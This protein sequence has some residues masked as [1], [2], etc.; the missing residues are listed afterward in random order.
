MKIQEIIK[1]KNRIV[2]AESVS[3]LKQ[4]DYG[5]EVIIDLHNVDK[6][7]FDTKIIRKF[8]EELC[9]EIG[10]TRGPIYL[11][12][13]DKSLGTMHNP[14]ADGISCIQFLYTSSITMHCIDELGKIFINVFSCQT[15]D[16]DKVKEFVLDTFGGDIVSFRN[17]KRK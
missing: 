17:I 4:E 16:A 6:D 1:N 3:E 8:A 7:L 9:D 12:G 11:W 10:M 5:Q 2:E 15:F 13:N 14:K